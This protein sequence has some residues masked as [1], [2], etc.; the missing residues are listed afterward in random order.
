ML[1]M[2]LKRMFAAMGRRYDYDV[3]YMHE[4]VDADRISARK[5]AFAM[6]FFTQTPKVPGKAYWAANLRATMQA[7]CGPCLRLVATMAEENGI[8]SSLIW[9]ILSGTTADDDA[10]L[11][12]DYADAVLSNSPE[13][14][15]LIH[16]I[17]KAWGHKGLASLSKAVCSGQFFPTFKRGLGHG[18]ACEPVMRDL[19]VRLAA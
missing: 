2:I 14:P 12:A 9:E 11:G 3:T 5:F 10:R 13:L 6:P 16:R 1:T 15:E 8:S 4:L 7:D 18:Q 17:S 19:E